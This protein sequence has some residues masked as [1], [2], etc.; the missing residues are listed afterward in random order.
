MSGATVSS[1]VEEEYLWACTLTQAAKSYQ[2]SPEDPS[3]LQGDEAADPSVKPGHRL[4]IKSAILMPGAKKDEV[5]IV[6][7]ESEGFGGQQVSVPMVAMRGGEDLQTYVD[8][9]VRHQAT[10]TLAQGSGPLHLFGSHCVDFYGYRDTG[11]GEDT[12]EEE[13]EEEAEE[14]AE[15]GKG[16]EAAKDGKKRKGSAEQASSQEKKAKAAL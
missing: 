13:E 4:L 5:N 2:W 8:I 1:P 7:I 9:L 11:A 3:D 14:E 15:V 10:I 16:D 12:E 6:R